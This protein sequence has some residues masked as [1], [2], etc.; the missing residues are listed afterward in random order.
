[1]LGIKTSTYYR[2]K[3]NFNKTEKKVLHPSDRMT[4][5]SLTDDEKTLILKT[6]NENPR[7]SLSYR[8]CEE[9]AKSEKH[10]ISLKMRIEFFKKTTENIKMATNGISN[11]MMTFSYCN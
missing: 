5:R 10:E 9:F 2:W 7:E 1:M 6:K 11:A 3:N 4:T 8:T